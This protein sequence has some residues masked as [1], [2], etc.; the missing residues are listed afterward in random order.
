MRRIGAF[1]RQWDPRVLKPASCDMTMTNWP[2]L[3][4]GSIN[5]LNF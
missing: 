1:N 2:G 5:A 3:A 4:S